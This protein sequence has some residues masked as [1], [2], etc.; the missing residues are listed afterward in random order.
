MLTNSLEVAET[1][2]SPDVRAPPV[3]RELRG[4]G[5]RLTDCDSVVYLG[6][7]PTMAKLGHNASL[8]ISLRLTNANIS[9][10]TG[11]SKT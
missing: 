7:S 6:T 1:Q 11:K 3:I 9:S 4:I 2:T 10:S 5:D 8:L